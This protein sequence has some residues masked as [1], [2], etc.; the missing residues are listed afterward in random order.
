MSHYS[1]AEDLDLTWQAA[2]VEQKVLDNARSLW[3][4]SVQQNIHDAVSFLGICS[5]LGCSSSIL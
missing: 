3:D 4:R 1:A 5:L 2:D